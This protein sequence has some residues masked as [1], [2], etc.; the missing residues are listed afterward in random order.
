MFVVALFSEG[1]NLGLEDG[2]LSSDG[3]NLRIRFFNELFDLYSRASA[4]SG[5]L[6]EKN[7]AHGKRGCGL[8]G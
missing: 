7:G 1:G 3:R 4:G 8:C 5:G 6:L 2:N